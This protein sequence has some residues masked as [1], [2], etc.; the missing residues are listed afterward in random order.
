MLD[1]RRIKA[2]SFARQGTR[3]DEA[4]DMALIPDPRWLLP[5]KTWQEVVDRYVHFR[6]VKARLG[7]SCDDF[8]IA[9]IRLA[10]RSCNVVKG[11]MTRQQ[12][13]KEA[14]SLASA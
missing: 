1:A 9:N 12:F 11:Q 13:F 5:A 8:D 10:C 7:S 3:D 2:I 14:R 4:P 6:R